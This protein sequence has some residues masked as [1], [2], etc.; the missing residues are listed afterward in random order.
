[1]GA[2][3]GQ[4]EVGGGGGGVAVNTRGNSVLPKFGSY[5]LMNLLV[6][7]FTVRA[8]GGERGK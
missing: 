6:R 2:R 7:N 4:P 8:A 5:S 1:M 3:G